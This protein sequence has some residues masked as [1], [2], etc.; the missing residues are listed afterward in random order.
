MTITP[1]VRQALTEARGQVWAGHR[2]DPNFTGCGIGYRRRGGV[3]TSEPVVVAMVVDKLPAAALSSRRL[4]PASVRV[5]GTDYGVDVV[6][7]GPVYASGLADRVAPTSLTTTGP[8]TG[9]YRPL[10]Q[11]C[12]ISNADIT[13][14]N[15]NGRTASPAPAGTVG[16]FVIDPN[17]FVYMVSAGHVLAGGINDWSPGSTSNPGDINQP[18]VP[19]EIP[20][21]M[22]PVATIT[23]IATL[24][25]TPDSLDNI[26]DCGTAI[27]SS[28]NTV[29]LT[30]ADD[31]MPP[32]SAAHPAVGMCIASDWG[33]NA[34][35]ARMDTTLNWVG[36]PLIGSDAVGAWTTAPQ[37]G[38]NIEKVGRS[39]GY[40]SSTV[41]ATDVI[42][43]VRY[44]DA[45]TN[46]VIPV[47]M[48]GLIWSQYFSIGGDSGA[49]ACQ[50]G[51]GHTY[52]VPLI[53]L[54]P[55]LQLVQS[56]YN[57]PNNPSDNTLTNNLQT[58]MLTQ[59][60]CGNLLIGLVYM[61]QQTVIGRLTSDTGPAF[62]QAAAQAYFQ[63]F[64]ATYRPV[65]ASM[66]TSPGGFTVTPAMATDYGY[67]VQMLGAQANGGQGLLTSQEE[68]LAEWAGIYLH[69]MAASNYTYEQVQALMDDASIYNQVYAYMVNIPTIVLP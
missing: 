66:L 25:T 68:G 60:V 33:G 13:Y 4:L 16:C 49:V 45:T 64:Y 59:T 32:I 30:F 18:A 65:I 43:T 28:P 26:V 58:K 53:L 48:S 35:L 24:D 23:N 37:V 34:F 69:A 3:V 57:L 11:G 40:S 36:M 19:D 2:K 52:A 51:D 46:T 47:T 20:L 31:L 15:P 67:A 29:S 41:D 22:D 56:Y 61:N 63:Q 5:N 44:P 54:C 50:G 62:N 27:I 12:S 38:M 21:H 10:V 1:Q 6:E 17:G 39:S 8:L 7:A 55:L 42:A 14:S 9:T